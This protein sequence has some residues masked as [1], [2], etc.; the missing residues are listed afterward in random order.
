[1]H[2]CTAT[3]ILSP[4]IY[5]HIFET[6]KHRYVFVSQAEQTIKIVCRL[7][8]TRHDLYRVCTITTSSNWPIAKWKD[9]VLVSDIGHLM[10]SVG[11]TLLFLM[12]SGRYDPTI[13]RCGYDWC[14]C[15]CLPTKKSNVGAEMK[16]SRLCRMLLEEKVHNDKTLPSFLILFFARRC[17][18]LP[19]VL[20][21]ISLFCSNVCVCLVYSFSVLSHFSLSLF[22]LQNL[23]KFWQQ[24]LADKAFF[25]AC[26]MCRIDRQILTSVKFRF[27]IFISTIF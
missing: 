11:H 27:S 21:R 22:Q 12:H 10:F 14:V 6:I 3:R 5:S 19:F 25:S 13:H 1:M 7:M 4:N 15:A 26:G 24:L 9:I 23:K 16:H 20:F 17:T 18:I 2:I 8:R